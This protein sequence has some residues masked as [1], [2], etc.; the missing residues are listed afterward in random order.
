MIDNGEHEV[1]EG[2]GW[3]GKVFG[4]GADGCLSR[5]T[6]Q[7]VAHA[8]LNRG[9]GGGELLGSISLQ[10]ILKAVRLDDVSEG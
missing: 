10:V 1:R 2:F 8:G 6:R 9:E 5:N 7:A 4:P 3:K